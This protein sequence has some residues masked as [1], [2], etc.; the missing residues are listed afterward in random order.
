MALSAV[1]YIHGFNSSP[2][3]Q[4]ARQ[5]AG[6]IARNRPDL[7]VVTP[8]VPIYPGEAWL[9]LEQMARTLDGRDWGVV[10]SSL[11]GYWATALSQRYGCP[12]VLINP[13]VHPYRLLKD[14]LGQGYNP[15]TQQHYLLEAR[16]MEELKALEV[17]SLA[18]PGRLWLL[19]QA[20]DEILDHRLA[21]AKYYHARV[22]V[23]LGGN[24]R[25][26][27]FSRYLEQIVHFLEQSCS[28]NAATDIK[29]ETL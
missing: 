5:L 1:V 3:S 15:Y 6:W 9:T 19:L 17:D 25:F 23:E 7:E 8:V 21:L 14:Y 13:A 20:E 16:H 18:D 22:T 28:V 2:D 26:V 10:G 24:H 4:K 12:A 27:G 29:Q 11:G